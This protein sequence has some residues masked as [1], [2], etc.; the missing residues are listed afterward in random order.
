MP[1][2]LILSMSLM[3]CTQCK[4]DL[5]NIRS[6]GIPGHEEQRMEADKEE[7]CENVGSKSGN[8]DLRDRSAGRKARTRWATIRVCN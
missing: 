8:S 6:E 4:Y 5:C 1:D 7:E 3:L 2:A